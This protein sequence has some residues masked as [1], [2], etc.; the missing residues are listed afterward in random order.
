M[1]KMVFQNLGA[2]WALGLASENQ[3]E[4]EEKF[5]SLYNWGATNGEL[6]WLSETPGYYFA[7]IWTSENKLKKYF[8]NI[9]KLKFDVDRIIN[10]PLQKLIID[11]VTEKMK[12]LSPE[13]FLCLNREQDFY[14]VGELVSNNFEE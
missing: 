13:T 14:T 12:T 7:Y 4:I 11:R 1:V 9:E 2:S 10:K 6:H 5:L 3:H 8:E